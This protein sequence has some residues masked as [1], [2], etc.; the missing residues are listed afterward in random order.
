MAPHLSVE[1]GIEPEITKNFILHQDNVKDASVWYHRGKLHA[2]VIV[3]EGCNFAPSD[4]KEACVLM[5]GENQAPVDIK[6][7]YVRNRV[8]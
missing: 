2:E 4:L 8:A 5:L 6:F 1:V 7:V 3:N